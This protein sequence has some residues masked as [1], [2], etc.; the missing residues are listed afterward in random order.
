M[1]QEP[2]D[3]ERRAEADHVRLAN[4]DRPQLLR[5]ENLGD[6]VDTRKHRDGNG[7]EAEVNEERRQDACDIAVV[8]RHEED[9][10]RRDDNADAADR[11]EKWR[12]RLKDGRLAPVDHQADKHQLAHEDDDANDLETIAQAEV[13]L[14]RATIEAVR[15]FAL[16]VVV[17]ARFVAN[18]VLVAHLGVAE[19]DRLLA[20]HQC[21]AT[22][23]L[24]LLNATDRRPGG[25]RDRVAKSDDLDVDVACF[26]LREHV[27]GTCERVRSEHVVHLDWGSAIDLEETDPALDRSDRRRERIEPEVQVEVLR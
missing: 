24:D 23:D 11:G 19:A 9:R 16:V 8:L 13:D 17:T 27:H 6:A 20:V 4:G 12:C 3:P 2:K 21:T 1:V 18:A 25:I 26:A 5:V 22:R 14:A 7:D 10:S 15:T